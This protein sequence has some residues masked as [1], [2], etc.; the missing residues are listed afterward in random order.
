ME[1]SYKIRELKIDEGIWILFIMLSIANIFG[2]E[3]EKKFYQY[4]SLSSEKK[5]KAIFFISLFISFFIY[6]YLDYQKLGKYYE[7]K[8]KGADTTVCGIRFLGE[9]LVVIA[10][11]LF[12]YCQI[13]E[14]NPEN[15]SIV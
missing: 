12:L 14:Q 7:A 6:C 1:N 11:L 10:T 3:C 2:D 9:T 15:P 4:D 13:V 5:A 8:R